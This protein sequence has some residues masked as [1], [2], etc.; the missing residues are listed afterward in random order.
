M[1]TESISSL[2]PSLTPLPRKKEKEQLKK[3]VNQL[4]LNKMALNYLFDNLFYVK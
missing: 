4:P 3:S 2:I 1:G